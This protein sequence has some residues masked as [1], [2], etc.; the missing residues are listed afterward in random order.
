MERRKKVV[1][2]ATGGTIAGEGKPGDATDYIPGKVSIT[3]IA[4]SIRGL[5][6]IAEIEEIQIANLNSDD[7]TSS[8]WLML[9]S[10]I[11]KLSKDKRID[12]FV[13]THG[14]DTMEETAY[15]LHLVVKTD[16]PVVVT[17]A[18]RPSTATSAD[19]PM[20]FYQ[21][22]TVAAS[23]KARGMGVLCVFSDSIYSAR[24]FQKLSTTSVTAFGGR[25]FGMMGYVLDRNVLLYN[26][27][28]KPHTTQ[29]EFSIDNID[30]LPKV[31][32]LIFH[33]DA[34]PDLIYAVAK[35][36]DGLVIVGA[37]NGNYSIRYNEVI[38]KLSI[39]V[40]RSSRIGNGMIVPDNTFDK[41]G[42][43]IVGDNL[44]PTKARI[45][46]QLAL[47]KTKDVEKIKEYFKKY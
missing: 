5:D 4:S 11:N 18:M 6:E 22:V 2:L 7:I 19:G 12:G 10:A 3:D 30:A 29:S 43:I 36:S 34:D 20:N 35:K 27:S 1:V 40:V 47:T 44:A 23:E 42:N 24:D 16:K 31:G 13:I 46:L 25:D 8:L 38:G 33:V 26:K 45:L 21:A 28:L 17:G 32:I 15:F 9:A 14:T 41:W 39:P 37:G